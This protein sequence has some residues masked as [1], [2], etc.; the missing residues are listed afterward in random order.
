MP[1]AKKVLPGQM[2][3]FSFFQ[4]KGGLGGAKVQ[5]PHAHAAEKTVEGR[6]RKMAAQ[7]KEQQ[8][9][10]TKKALSATKKAAK[11]RAGDATNR[12]KKDDKKAASMTPEQVK[13]DTPVERKLR[14]LQPYFR[15]AK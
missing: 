9:P 14:V 13:S 6:K 12:P 3:M 11:K 15:Y 4:I 5:P 7:G 2:S 1:P 8:V 10:P